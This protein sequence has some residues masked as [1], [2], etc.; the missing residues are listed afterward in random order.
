MADAFIGEV[1]VF[2][3]GWAPEGWFL[4]NGA[5]LQIQQ[6]AALYSLLGT[7]WGGDGQNTFNLPN[8]Q[9][10]VLLGAGQGLGLTPRVLGS[11]GATGAPLVA[12]GA[13]NLPPHTHSLAFAGAARGSTGTLTAVPTATAMP[14]QEVTQISTFSDQPADSTL[15][16]SALGVAGVTA[17]LQPHNNVQPC[18]AMQFYIC[19]NGIYP[20]FE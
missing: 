5:Q 2:P 8:F 11:G 16:P 1:R 6:N 10:Y 18:L 14:S 19:W 9:G 7:R 20:D 13:N 3:W 4:C 12:L 17:P 15:D